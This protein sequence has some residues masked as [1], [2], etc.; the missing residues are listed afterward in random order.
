MSK[1]PLTIEPHDPGECPFIACGHSCVCN[2]AV[3]QATNGGGCRC[4]EKTLRRAARW[5]RAKAEYLQ[6]NVCSWEHLLKD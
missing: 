3:G 2:K 6:Q 1:K 5:W 4:D